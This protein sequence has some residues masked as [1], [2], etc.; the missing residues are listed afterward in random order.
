VH[1]KF[2]ETTNFGAKKD[3]SIIGDGA[4]NINVTNESI[5]IIVEDV[6]EPPTT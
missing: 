4:E 2:D 3:Y 1:V 6:Q 5:A